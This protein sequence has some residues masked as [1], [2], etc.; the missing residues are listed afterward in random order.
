LIPEFDMTNAVDPFRAT[1]VLDSAALNVMAQRLEARGQHPFFSGLLKD[2]LDRME[3]D[4]RRMVLDL[5]CGTGVVARAVAKRPAFYGSVLGVDLS[6]QLIRTA[7]ELA[8]NDGLGERTRFAVGNSM[9]LEIDA[10]SFDAVIAHTLF[11]HIEDP[12]KTLT[13]IS[14]VLRAE[15]VIA[16]FDGDYASLTFD[17]GDDV[18]SKHMED[19]I[20]A[21][22][23]T[24][25]RVMRRMPTL[26]KKAGFAIEA[27]LPFIVAETG[28]ADFWKG[29]IEAYAALAPRAGL[30][31]AQD[32]AV[33]RDE[34][35][36][37]SER[38]TFFGACTYYAYI[39]RNAGTG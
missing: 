19:A 24:Q 29:G 5:G 4:R 32:A 37:A 1:N 17:L 34:L 12:G 3:I 6:E 26:L 15:G 33:W 8:A 20:V 7:I 31:S 14:R 21:S 18:R 11:S 16:I 10:A 28:A 25:P 9:A 38:G 30:L 23:V 35:L 13:E 22:L 27:V 2:Y 36:A 39:A